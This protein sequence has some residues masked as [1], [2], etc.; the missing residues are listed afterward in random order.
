MTDYDP[1][2]L[3]YLVRVGVADDGHVSTAMTYLDWQNAHRNQNGV[4][5]TRLEET[6]GG[7]TLRDAESNYIA[8]IMRLTFK[9]QYLAEQ[10]MAFL[11]IKPQY[12]RIC[13]QSRHKYLEVL[14]QLG[15]LIDA[16]QND[17]VNSSCNS[18]QTQIYSFS[19]PL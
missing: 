18:T 1:S 12:R 16:I 5:T 17:T 2:I 6:D 19:V 13:Y 11:P 3:H 8:L 4:R 7:D 15:A 10:A 9:Q 14:D